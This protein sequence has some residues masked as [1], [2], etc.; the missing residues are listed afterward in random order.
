[1]INYL[2]NF[3]QLSIAILI[4]RFLALINL[5]LNFRKINDKYKALYFF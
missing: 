5:N 2:I 1:M 3:F 4:F